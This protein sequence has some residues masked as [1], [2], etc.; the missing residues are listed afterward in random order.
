PISS[1][2]GGERARLLLAKIMARESNLL[3]LDEPTNH[4]DL[5]MRHALTLALQ[6]FAGAV[7]LVTHDRHLL[8]NTADELWLIADGTVEVYDGDVASYERAIAAETPGESRRPTP[9]ARAPA[10]AEEDARSRRQSAAARRE[11]LKPLRASLRSLEQEMAR[12]ESEMQDLQTRLADPSLYEGDKPAELPALLKR[13]GELRQLTESLEE[14][15][16]ETQEALDS[17]SA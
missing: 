3:V 2:S 14:R 15:W 6:A 13:E 11:Q 12:T 17:I 9:A 5:E 4:L 7:L 10:A 16:L 1:L 8:R